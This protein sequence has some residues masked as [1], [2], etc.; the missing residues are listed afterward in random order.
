MSVSFINAADSRDH[1]RSLRYS[2]ILKPKRRRPS[3]LRLFFIAEKMAQCQMSGCLRKERR[4]LFLKEE[5]L[6]HVRTIPK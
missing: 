3:D 2:C 4:T 5:K 6:N 1:L